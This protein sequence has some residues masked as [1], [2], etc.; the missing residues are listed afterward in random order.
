M[1]IL[2]LGDISLKKSNPK[3]ILITGAGSGLGKMAAI[4]LAKRGHNVY[5]TTMYENEAN[6]LQ[7]YAN[8]NSLNITSFKMDINSK[9]DRQRISGIYFD[10]LI[11]NA[12]IGDSGSISEIN[13]DRF[14]NVFETNVFSNIQITQ[15]VL[16]EMIKNKKG[17]IIFI[18]SLAGKIPIAFLGPYC[19]SKFAIEGFA[20]CLRQEMLILKDTDIKVSIIEPGAFSTGFNKENNEKKYAWMKIESYFK[21]QLETI[22]KYETLFWN[23]IETRKYKKIIKK[24]VKAVEKESLTFRYSAPF[25]QW[26]ATKI[27]TI[28]GL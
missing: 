19:S 23:F 22:Q 20:N 25:S 10:V 3:K 1:Q 7:T 26:F 28:I 27:G 15:D 14:K 17:K 11:N 16:K 6:V 24:Y 5:A 18:A 21:P 9:K 4:A 12:A 2:L 8:A 13:I